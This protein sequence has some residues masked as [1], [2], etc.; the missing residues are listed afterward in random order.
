MELCSI[1]PYELITSLNIIS[2][3][4]KLQHMIGLPFFFKIVISHICISCIFFIHS[5]VNRHLACHHFLATVKNAAV[6]IGV[7]IL[8]GDLVSNSFG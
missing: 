1:C 6:S 5:S 8:L 7:Q 4:F 3:R 2:S